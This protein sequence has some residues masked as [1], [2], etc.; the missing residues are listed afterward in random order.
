[1]LTSLGVVYAWGSAESGGLGIDA[2]EDVD[3][4]SPVPVETLR[5]ASEIDLLKVQQVSAGENHTLCLVSMTQQ[6]DQEQSNSKR[7][8]VWGAND[9][10]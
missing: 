3:V 8:F 7:V 5:E 10:R 6:E 9:R 4:S 2:E 1:M